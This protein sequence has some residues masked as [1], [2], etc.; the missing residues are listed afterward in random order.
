M[1]IDIVDEDECDRLNK[2]IWFSMQANKNW[3]KYMMKC[4]KKIHVEIQLFRRS[5]LDIP[6]LKELCDQQ[7]VE[8]INTWVKDKIL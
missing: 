2:L 3:Y 1:I 8:C 4:K 6:L 5:N 7:H